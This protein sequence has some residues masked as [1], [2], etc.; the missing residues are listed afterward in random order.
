MSSVWRAAFGHLSAWSRSAGF[1]YVTGA[2]PVVIAAV[3]IAASG[4]T[5]V[6]VLATAVCAV[7]PLPWRRACPRLALVPMAAF[8]LNFLFRPE[9]LLSVAVA[10]LISLY[11]AARQRVL[12]PLLLTGAAVAGAVLVN[13]GHIRLG[14]YDLGGA[15]PI[16][17]SQGALSYFAESVLL[18]F[19]IVATVV[20]ADAAR[21]RELHRR[22]R[23]LAHEHLI[24]ME[25]HQAAVA[26]RTEIAR[27]LHDIVAHSVS[28]IAVQAESS[29]YSIPGLTPQAQE[30][31]Q[32]IARSARSALSELRG[33][34]GILRRSDGTREPVGTA[35]QPTLD[36]LD[37]LLERHRAACGEVELHTSGHRPGLTAAFELHVYRIVQE[38]LTNA[39][40]HAPGTGVRIELGYGADRVALRISN[41]APGNGRFASVPPSA[42]VRPAGSGP[43]HPRGHGL[44]GMRERAV[45]L[46]GSLTWTRE[47][48]GAFRIDAGFPLAPVHGNAVT[49]P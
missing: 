2:V 5:S 33:L 23:R 41:G 3:E 8:L 16:L 35:P 49:P 14:A 40:R 15:E 48:D 12:H 25:R 30:G 27:E 42:A 28:V 44:D 11:A 46:G 37:S 1:P 24:R 43:Q 32:E 9:L 10:G 45:L 17:G 22:D 19:A 13:W 20:L 31:F 18:S 29:T 34:V 6:T 7:A 36:S 38:A 4:I 39:R 26:A 47:P 21:G